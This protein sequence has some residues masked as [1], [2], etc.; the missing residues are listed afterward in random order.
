MLSCQPM[1]IY[2]T[3]EFHRDQQAQRASKTLLFLLQHQISSHPELFNSY[4]HGCNQNKTRVGME[5][6]RRGSSVPAAWELLNTTEV[7]LK[8]P[9]QVPSEAARHTLPIELEQRGFLYM[10]QTKKA[11]SS[12]HQYSHRSLAQEKES[13]RQ[14]KRTTC[15]RAG[16]QSK[17]VSVAPQ[18]QHHS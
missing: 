16:Y 3:T 18:R 8:K 9:K 10:P 12:S 14:I 5:A 2:Q 6:G 11:S 13:G 15:K 4:P 17:E 1:F 7:E